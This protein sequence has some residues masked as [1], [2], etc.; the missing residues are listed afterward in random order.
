MLLAI[1]AKMLLMPHLNLGFFTTCTLL[2]LSLICCLFSRKDFKNYA[3]VCFRTFGDRIK[4]WVTINEPMIMAKFGYAMGIAPPGRCSDRTTCPEG[5]A[6][7]E[8]YIVGHNLLLAH[9]AVA[10]LYKDKYQV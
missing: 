1:G 3:E 2:Y 10:R 7:T 8:P 6:A 9:A 5:N 4:H